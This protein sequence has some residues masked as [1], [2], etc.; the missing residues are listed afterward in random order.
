[1]D[2]QVLNEE[3]RID[4]DEFVWKCSAATHFHLGGWKTVLEA[5]F[6]HNPHYLLAKDGTHIRGILPL[7]PVNSRLTG[8]YVTSLP[9][10][11][12]AENEQTAHLLIEAAIDYVKRVHADYLILRDSLRKWDSPA[13]VTNDDHCT[14]LV[15]LDEDPDKIWCGVNRRTRQSIKKAYRADLQVIS[16]QNNLDIY[17][18]IYSQAL[19]ERGTPT[20]GHTFFDYL[21]REFPA[22]YNL[23]VVCRDEDILGG[24][25]VALFKDTIYNTWSGMLSQYYNLNTG[26]LLYWET[27]KFGCD[28]GYQ[29]VD[30]GRSEWDSG[31]FKFKKQWRGSP[32]PLYQQYYLNGISRPPSVG[33]QRADDLQYRIFIE[34]WKHLP[35]A[36]TE[37]LGTQIRKRMPFG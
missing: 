1:V 25:F 35:R 5:V 31:G 18:P 33:N 9:G 23:F 3:N 20:Q 24:G 29:W 30:L 15:E 27:L 32:K 28:T 19:Q 22:I 7:I 36:L 26:Y 16:G 37:L 6:G 14:F 10:G 8:R 4:W 17:Y 34:M 21:L 11:L 13:L 12:C 2:I